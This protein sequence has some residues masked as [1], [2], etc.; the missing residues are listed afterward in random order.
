MHMRFFALAQ[1]LLLKQGQIILAVA[2]EAG[3]TRFEV[4]NFTDGVAR[5][6]WELVHET[7]ED[8]TGGSPAHLE[9][10]NDIGEDVSDVFET[11]FPFFDFCPLL[12]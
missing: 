3:R 10:P 12:R 7:W 8:G 2:E 9:S 1:K 4:P 5:A 6:L 11:A